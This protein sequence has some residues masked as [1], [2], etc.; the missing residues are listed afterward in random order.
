MCISIHSCA[1]RTIRVGFACCAL[2]AWAAVS[3]M[4]AHMSSEASSIPLFFFPNPG[5]ADPAIQYLAE[6]PRLRAAFAFDSVTFQLSGETIRLQF[7]DASRAARLEGEA[8]LAGRANFLLGQNP[9][10]WHSGV[11]TYGG[12]LYRDL[13]PGIDLRYSGAGGWIKSEFIVAPRGDPS[14]IRLAYS[15]DL[16]IDE[17][18][19]L[20]A[21]GLRE[22]APEIYQVTSAGR[23]RVEGRYRLIGTRT[24]VLEIGAYDASLPLV[25]DPVLSYSTYMGGTGLGAVTGIA[26]DGVANLYATGWTEALNFPIVGAAQAVNGGGVD[27]FIVKLNPAGSALVYA[28]YIGGSGDDRGAGIAVDVSGEAY[29]TGST[30]S[31][32]F[33]VVAAAKRSLGGSKNAF[34]LKLN[35]TG[36]ALL[37]STYL[38]GSTYDVGTAIAIDGSGNAYV[39]GDTQS[40]NFPTLTPLQA[41]YGGATDSFVTKFSPAGAIV[42]STFLGGS[43]AE[44][45]GGIAVD[46]SGNVSIAG[47][48]YS[49]NFPVLGAIQ[50]ANGGSEDVFVTKIAAAGSPIVYSTYLGGSGAAPGDQ[51]NGIAI[52]S[53][54]NAYVTGVTGSSNFPVTTG[55]YQTSFG[56]VQDAF[57][58]KINAAGSALIYSSYLGGSDFD[59]GSG[60][61]VDSS[62]NAYVTGYTLSVNFASV[63][64]I[65]TTFGGAYDVFISELNP[66]GNAL[67]F[68]SYFGGSGSEVANSIALDTNANIFLGGQTSSVNLPLTGA[69]QTANTGGSTGWLA[70]L[71]V[72]SAPTQMPS[73]ISVSPSTGSGNSVTLTAQFGDTAGP[74]ALTSVALLINTSASKDF[75][76]YITYIPSTGML[77]LANDV[78]SSGSFSVPVGVSSVQNSQCSLNSVASSVATPVG[79]Y[80]TVTLAITFLPNFTPGLKTVYLYAADPGAN[81]GFVAQ[82]SYTVVIPA[83]LPSANLVSPN[84]SSGGSQTFTFT[85]SD[86]QNANN[87]TG[88]AMLFAPSLAFTNACYMVYDRTAGTISLLWDNAQGSNAMPVSS[89]TT[90]QNSQ[91]IV[92]SAS[93][94]YTGLSLTLSVA[95]TFK[96][97]FG[98][99]QNIYM[100]GSEGSLSTGWVQRGTYFV[101]AGGT[102]QATSVVPNN[103][104]GP[105]S[106]FSFTISDPGGANF[107]TG[108]AVLFAATSNTSNACYLVWDRTSN[109]ISLSYENPA[110]G[111]TP[112]V[113]GSNTT[114]SNS[115]CTLA[116]SDTTV[117][118]SSTSITITMD[119][120]FNAAWSGVKNIYLYASEGSVNSGWATVGTWTATGGAPTADSVIPAS[121]AGSSPNFT[122]QVSDS[123][124]QNNVTGMSMLITNGAPT[125]VGSACSLV[126][127][128]TAAIIGLYDDTGTLLSSKP[129]GSSANL[130]NSQCAVGYT[131]M[132]TSGNS[133]QFTINVVFKAAFDGAKTVYLQANEPSATS[134]WVQR[135]TWTVQ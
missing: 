83:P 90:L 57:V 73:A 82:G 63:N 14:R 24:A 77:S 108:M 8:P 55:A 104:S 106:R 32:N 118:I 131:V 28:T 48:T 19:D 31:P 79:G 128:R 95:V 15:V 5:V 101:Q 84:A 40:T 47:G 135:G 29:V 58:A 122:F 17:K 99:L 92:G 87:I 60:I 37:Y 107:L 130:Q 127:N 16:A 119:L 117:A 49:T 91:C 53:S 66:A 71:G 102:P 105:G 36:N 22:R 67:T 88:A 23:V 97:A 34:A 6:G 70:R 2:L 65:R 45:S 3:L 123:F 132:V 30:A 1:K 12:L 121:G 111:S 116:A 51:A 124:S 13:Y 56:G 134:G 75:G 114:A 35:A 110:N 115:E 33:P 62:G 20:L 98:G 109:R 72:T 112:V 4:G 120:S 64:P 9:R 80:L 54:G 61:K 129:I 125:N 44:H 85:F 39:A 94:N 52:D 133:V 21:G 38:G 86:T 18:G 89:L 78:A 10:D 74:S 27:A 46:A 113:P 41:I 96:A 93:A 11:A 76:C 7:Q 43:A 100:Y 103:G 69:I 50:S 25:I 26:V 59:W 42:F 126:Y 68:S 81:T